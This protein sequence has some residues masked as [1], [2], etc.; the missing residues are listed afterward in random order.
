MKLS[1]NFAFPTMLQSVAWLSLFVFGSLKIENCN[2]FKIFV[3][4]PKHSKSL[5]EPHAHGNFCPQR[6]PH[7]QVRFL[8]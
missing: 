4:R 2:Q 5:T 1:G 8:A 3:F 7:G 6:P